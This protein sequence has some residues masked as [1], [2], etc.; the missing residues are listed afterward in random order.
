MFG[1]KRHSRITF[2]F[3]TCDSVCACIHTCCGRTLV[4]FYLLFS[5][6]FC[7]FLTVYMTFVWRIACRWS[8]HVGDNSVFL[9]NVTRWQS[10]YLRVYT[11]I[12][13][14]MYN[15][16]YTYV[17]SYV[18][19]EWDSSENSVNMYHCN[20]YRCSVHSEIYIVHSQT[21][22]LFIILGKV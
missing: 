5:N 21:N 15:M 7:Y 8:K 14:E 18:S 11:C 12:A 9:D 1:L 3:F 6:Y 17:Y 13:R 19:D 2:I 22:A 20:I 4:F 16:K 10:T